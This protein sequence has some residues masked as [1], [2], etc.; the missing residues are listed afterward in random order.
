MT[1]HLAV[2]LLV[3]IIWSVLKNGLVTEILI[4][5][6]YYATKNRVTKSLHSFRMFSNTNTSVNKITPQ[7]EHPPFQSYVNVKV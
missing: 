6:T 7:K 4:N 2:V 3:T 5:N 1:M